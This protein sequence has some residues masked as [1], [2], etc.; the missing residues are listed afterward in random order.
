[1]RLLRALACIV[2]LMGLN[3]MGL[4]VG[5]ASA[6][7]PP[8]AATAGLLLPGLGG[9]DDGDDGEDDDEDEGGGDGGGTNGGQGC[10]RNRDCDDGNACN[11]K[12]RCLRTLRTCV[13]G[14]PLACDDGDRCN[15]TET[16]NPEDGCT[17]G[18]PPGDCQNPPDLCALAPDGTQCPNDGIRCTRDVCR[19][20]ACTH[21]PDDGRCD[22][23]ACTASA[24]RPDDGDADGD[25][26]VSRTVGEG[27]PCTDDGVA[28]TEDVCGD[29]DCRHVP[30]DSRCGVADGCTNVACVPGSGDARGC[31]IAP[32]APEGA[33]CSEDGNPC[34]TDVCDAG[35]CVHAVVDRPELCVP[36][37]EPFRQALA[38]GALARSIQ[39][40]LARTPLAQSARVDPRIDLAARLEPV[41]AALEL[42]AR[43]LAGGPDAAA[44]P[45]D[46]NPDPLET[47]AS[48]RARA[49]L[50]IF[51]TTRRQV[52]TF[53]RALAGAR[54]RGLLDA[55]HARDL[56]RRGKT[57][58][59][60]TQKLRRGVRRLMRLTGTFTR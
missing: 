8:D 32:L 48:E 5:A 43:T 17:P 46:T 36:L 41:A 33:F 25:G 2:L 55:D 14:A 50:P 13:A 44:G 11:G 20:G 15:G 37:A 23:G 31:V 24:C 4:D 47:L 58:F 30:I 34:T 56:R 26:C 49:A 6:G 10:R 28:C 9:D 59:E 18:V 38:L 42:T 16:C 54:T 57:L 52:G 3:V 60:G 12:E 51:R 29:G 39:N 35:T 45:V 40:D 22:A 21:V 1:V 27:E 53:M 19:A 7:E